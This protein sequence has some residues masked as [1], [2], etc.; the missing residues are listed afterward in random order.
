MTQFKSL[1]VN[2]LFTILDETQQFVYR[3]ISSSQAV[4]NGER[5]VIALDTEVDRTYDVERF[6]EV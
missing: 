2:S 5:Y 3:K 1:P 6:K 4:H